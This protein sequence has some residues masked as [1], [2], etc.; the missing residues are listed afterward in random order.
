MPRPT[1]V[2]A[3]AGMGGLVAAV[4]G[5]ELGARVTLLEK[6]D[7]PGGSMRLSGGY[8]WRYEDFERFRSECPSGDAR[9]QRLVYERLDDALEWLERLGV[10]VLE[11]ETRNPLTTGRR[12]DVAALTDVLV[13]R[14]G[15]VRLG[16]PLEEPPPDAPVVLATGGFAGSRDLL[17]RHVTAEAPYVLVRAHPGNAGDGIRIGLDAGAALSDGMDEVYGRNMPA[18]PARVSPE[19]FRP[20]AQLYAAHARVTNERGEEYV[21]RSW[22]EIDVLQWTARQ[23]RARAWYAV[24]DGALDAT[25]RERTVR[26]MVEAA[27]AAGAPVRRERGLTVVEVV[28]GVTTTLGGL[29]V[30]DRARA[31]EGI[32]A[33]GMD[34]GGIAT[35]GY[36]SGL[37]AALVLGLVAAESALG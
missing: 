28:A 14:A 15:E 11:R 36:T 2:V 1:L 3:G 29:R 26:E 20:L 25:V 16:T 30:D 17:A 5:R 35:G 23:P 13:R 32:Y 9:L 34:A 22:S 18:P 7:R 10:P 8:V 19:E 4:R 31:A 6:S 24:D 27:Q 21:P 37:A 33:A 12:V